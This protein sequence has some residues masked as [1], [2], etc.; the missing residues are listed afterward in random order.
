MR[1]ARDCAARG[2][3]PPYQRSCIDPM[4][5]SHHLDP[6]LKA[7]GANGFPTIWLLINDK[8]LLRD[9][10]QNDILFLSLN[11]QLSIVFHNQIW[12]FIQQRKGFIYPLSAL[13]KHTSHLSKWPS[14]LIQNGTLENVSFYGLVFHG[15]S[16]GIILSDLIFINHKIEAPDW[17]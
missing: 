15:L 17:L 13:A 1:F 6:T 4:N 5:Q 16:G 11:K 8:I 12:H 14:D 7:S 10:F 9:R 2:W 3:S